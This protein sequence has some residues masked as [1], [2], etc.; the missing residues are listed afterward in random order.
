MM[1]EFKINV[2]QEKSVIKREI[3]SLERKIANLADSMELLY[4]IKRKVDTAARVAKNSGYEDKGIKE[5]V[6]WLRNDFKHY[7]RQVWLYNNDNSDKDEIAYGMGTAAGLN[8]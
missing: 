8:R 7:I 6:K 1:T 3:R 4:E 5:D 2:E